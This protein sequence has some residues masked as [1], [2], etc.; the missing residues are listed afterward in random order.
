L[1]KWH[2]K[3]AIEEISFEQL[4]IKTSPKEQMV[5]GQMAIEQMSNEQ[6]TM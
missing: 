1:N 3:K 4:K 2:Y 5:I 6:M